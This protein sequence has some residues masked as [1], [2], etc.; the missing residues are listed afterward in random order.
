VPRRRGCLEQRAYEAI[1][2]PPQGQ[3]GHTLLLVL[4]LDRDD[5]RPSPP[6][7]QRRAGK[8]PRKPRDCLSCRLGLAAEKSPGLGLR[9]RTRQVRSS[10]TGIRRVGVES[11]ILSVLSPLGVEDAANWSDVDASIAE[12]FVSR[13]ITTEAAAFSPLHVTRTLSAIPLCGF[14]QLQRE[15]VARP[16]R[17]RGWSAAARTVIGGGSSA[18]GEDYDVAR[19]SA[20]G[21][22]RLDRRT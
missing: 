22:A 16:S 5:H 8:R 13:L 21:G 2:Q 14:A 3:L 9:S 18:Y 1:A 6:R 20:R 12:P 7:S 19:E 10:Q 15:A 4:V 17:T 11:G